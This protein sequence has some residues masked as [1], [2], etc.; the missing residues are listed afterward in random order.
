MED[1]HAI[2]S[3]VRGGVAI[4]VGVEDGSH[5]AVGSG[6][7]IERSHRGCFHPQ[8][9]EGFDQPNDSEAGPEALFR[10]RPF[11]QAFKEQAA[12]EPGKDMNGQEEARA[13][14][15]PTPVWRECA[16]KDGWRSC[17]AACGP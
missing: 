12:V 4:K 16:A 11:F 2:R 13:A 9:A 10:M 14:G 3:A 1:R 7:D 5:R 8:R 6:A 15:D 17:A